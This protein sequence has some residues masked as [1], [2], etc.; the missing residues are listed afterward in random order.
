[1]F[2]ES[3]S[4]A[5]FSGQSMDDFIDGGAGDDTIFGMAGNDQLYGGDGNDLIV[6]DESTLYSFLQGD[7]YLDGGAGDDTLAGLGGNDTLNGGTGDDILEGGDGDDRY[8]FAAGDGNDTLTENTGTDTLVF[9]ATVDPDQMIV[10]ALSGGD[11]SIAYGSGDTLRIVGGLTGVVE[12]IETRAGSIT[13]AQFADKYITTGLNLNTADAGGALAL[14]GGGGNDT[15]V[16]NSPNATLFG[17]AG[18]DLM[19]VQT[20]AGARFQVKSGDGQDRVLGG[21]GTGVKRFAFENDIDP[22]SVHIVK[23]GADTPGR[24]TPR[25]TIIRYGDGGDQIL[26]EANSHSVN[27]TYELPDGSTIGEVQLLERS[28]LSL[29]WQG[30]DDGEFVTATRYDDT[31]EGAGG[32]DTLY[33]RDGNDTLTGGGGNDTLYGENGNDVLAGGAGNDD[34]EGGAGND[35]YIVNAGEGDDTIVDAEGAN[36]VR[37]TGISAADVSASLVQSVGGDSVLVLTYGQPNQQEHLFIRQSFASAATGGFSFEFAGGTL[38]Q[39]Q[40]LATALPEA[41]DFHAGPNSVS[42]TGSRFADTIAGSDQADILDGAEGNG[43]LLGGGGRDTLIGGSGDD[44]LDGGSGDDTLSGG[45]G[46][47]TYRFAIGM[48]RDSIIETGSDVNTLALDPGIAI[49]D[50]KGCRIGEDLYLHRAGSREGVQ[51]AGYFAA[52]STQGWQ[53][54]DAVGMFTPLATVVATLVEDVRPVTLAQV[55]QDYLDRAVGFYKDVLT[56][57]GWTLGSDGKYQYGSTT[58]SEYGTT[59]FSENIQST[60]EFANV[61]ESSD[62][63][64]VSPSAQPIETSTTSDFSSTSATVTRQV[65]PGGTILVPVTSGGNYASLNSSTPRYIDPTGT[66]VTFQSGGATV[67]AVTS[68]VAT[69]GNI[70]TSGGAI[71]GYK[72]YTTPPTSETVT[73][74]SYVSR[75]S[76]H[77]VVNVLHLVAGASDN[78]VTLNGGW[79]G[80][81]TVDLGGGNDTFSMDSAF[82]GVSIPR[83]SH[84][85]SGGAPGVFVDGGAGDDVIKTGANDDVLIGGAGNDILEGGAGNDTYV[86]YAGS[87]FD[88]VRDVGDS[89]GR[90]R[91]NTL[92]LPN[93]V[94]SADL[95]FSSGEMADSVTLEV[96]GGVIAAAAAFSTLGMSWGEGQGVS[97]VIPHTDQGPSGIDFVRFSDGTTLRF[98]DVMALAGTLPTVDPQ[99]LANFDPEIT[100]GAGGDDTLH[101]GDLGGSVSTSGAIGGAGQDTL[102]GS[103]QSDV[104]IGG[105]AYIGG[106]YGTRLTGQ[107]WDAGNTYRGGQGDDMLWATGGAD[108]F[109]LNAGDGEDTISDPQHEQEFFDYGG[110]VGDA[111]TD[112]ARVFGSVGDASAAEPA[113]L[114]QLLS[115][116]DTLRFG[117]GVAP[118]SVSVNQEGDD[119]V[120][121]VGETPDAVRFRNWFRA[122][123]NQ[124]N[125]VQFANGRVWDLATIYDRLAGVPEEN[126][127]PN[128]APTVGAQDTTVLYG[129]SKA[130]ASLF[131]VSDPDGDAIRQYEFWD[132]VEGGG[133]FATDGVQQAAGQAIPV[134]AADL[135][136]LRYVGGTSSGAEQVWVRANDGLDWSAWKNWTMTSSGHATNAAPVVSAGDATVII[137]QEA[138]ASDLFS[139]SDADGDAITKYEFWDDVN[140]GGHFSAS[141]VAQ[142]SGQAIAVSAVDLATLTYPAADS[143]SSEQVWVRAN[144]GLAWSAWKN[145]N[146]SSSTHATNTAP[147]VDA[148]TGHAALSQAVDASS[149]FSVS[150]A[151]GDTATKYEF[152]DDGAGGGHFAKAGVTQ[153]SGQAIAVEA[154]ELENFQYVGAPTSSSEQVWVRAND[155]LAWG[156]WKSWQ[157]VSSDHANN[158]APVVTASDGTVLIGSEVAAADL[159]SV[160]DA[161]NDQITQYEFWDD[162]SGDGHFSRSG[163]AQAAGQSIPVSAADLAALTYTASDTAGAEQVWVRANDGLEWSAWK[164]WTMQS[165]AHLTNSAPTVTASNTTILL[166]QPVLAST[167][168][169]AS[170]ADGDAMTKYEFWDDGTGGGHF[171]KAGVAQA[172]G[173]AIA[174]DA[175]E[176]PGFRYIGASSASVEQVWVRAND[177]LAWS[178]WKNWSITSASH[179]TN[180]APTVTAG[181]AGVL[182]G[183]SVDAV[184]LFTVNDT[185][186]DSM[187]QYEFW[188]D[189]AGGGYFSKAGVAQNAAQTIAVAAAELQNLSYV[190]GATA[191]QEQVWVRANDGQAWSAWKNWS[192]A[193]LAG[194]VRGGSGDDTLAGQSGNTVLEGNGGDDALTDVQGNNLLNG[195]AG[196]DALTGGAGNDVLIGGTGND[197]IQTGGGN[198]V[199]VHNAGEGIDTVASD[200]GAANTVSLGG[201]T[202]YSNLS[203]AKNGNDLVLNTGTDDG[204][205]LK[206]WYDGHAN[207]VNLQ[208][209]IDATQ[210]FDASSQDPLYNKRVQTFD[211]AGLVQQFDAARAADPGLTSWGVTNALLQYHL[212]G[213]DDSALGGDLAYQYGKAGALTGIGLTSALD[214]LG[215]ADLGTLA[216]QLRPFSGLQEGLV[217]LA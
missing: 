160:I 104:L 4:D 39:A 151:D 193:T 95:T 189:V 112:F 199:I 117:E 86:F 140:G 75:N 157:M 196:N 176:L 26:V 60:L 11:L 71:T 198:N 34:L 19:V 45:L 115:S 43:T 56:Q 144:D 132:D 138:S 99:D 67:T 156:G 178:D 194:L 182:I 57:T 183:E 20:S 64:F 6:G 126:T 98:A 158:S 58:S 148:S 73:V 201:G 114:A 80:I 152:W 47:D 54:K 24:T 13:F 171:D 163:V 97:V 165:S 172:S 9:D 150:D 142:A 91:E 103:A 197:A 134:S 164:P 65:D 173:Q 74:T 190:G 30:S 216:Q 107:L 175:T 143:A 129:Q 180:S 170:D 8:M 120:F 82:S 146:M 14:Y 159:F 137:G 62:D 79:S 40:L 49:S 125:Q 35:T 168:Y 44:L 77:N 16:A 162:V 116:H 102:I 94:T 78:A 123:V 76:E 191:G 217:K 84:F 215:S 36:L 61:A 169:S 72:I 202:D 89:G 204:V 200:A 210:A 52:G 166:D 68:S 211:F 195:G 108:V 141:G 37:L 109:E 59:S 50:L 205:V 12:N 5:F 23:T 184:G 66:L 130:A 174:V 192:M 53:V 135:A 153:A 33:G 203:L 106:L 18:D 42:I 185:D 188:D 3:L 128:H 55:R 208:M 46:S 213:A 81:A 161:D 41:L 92:V 113:H 186:G 127:G 63:P 212:S 209:I 119:L 118:S 181:T 2:G 179:L 139:V 105:E 83:P 133:Y 155:G 93:G 214:V 187:A 17:G 38:T 177:G 101:A 88:R 124:L 21:N 122:E 70:N 136:N 100:Y 154:S 69:P 131:S 167:L 87:G 22:N 31:L 1:M 32:S 206:D 207:V 27:Q 7:D 110:R 85:D 28:G 111:T 29:D 10:T 48:G 121:R 15:L 145:W 149:L 147:S 51:I 90:E 96:P 25:D